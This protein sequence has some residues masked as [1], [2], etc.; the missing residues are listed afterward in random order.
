VGEETF[1]GE[2]CD[3]VDSI[4]RCERLWVSRQTG[5]LRGVVKYHRTGQFSQGLSGTLRMLPEIFKQTDEP[6]EARAQTLQIALQTLDDYSGPF[7]PNE[8][9]CFRDFRQ[10]APDAW[11]P[12]REDRAFTHSADSNVNRRK[13]IRLWW[14]AEEVRTDVDLAATIQILQPKEGDR[15]SQDQRFGLPLTYDYHPNRT[16]RELLELVQRERYNPQFEGFLSMLTFS[17]EKMAGEPARVLPAE[18]W[19]GGAVPRTHGTPHLLHFWA[20]W[21]SPSLDDFPSLKEL[22]GEGATILGIHPA[23][24]PAA[25]VAQVMA[26]HQLK[27]PTLLATENSREHFNQR[28]AGY[29][30][31]AYPHCVLIDAEGRIAAQGPLTP[32]LLE[33][34]R[35][36]R[37]AAKK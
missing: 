29:P 16:P 35:E 6:D 13:Y 22:A 11:F 4:R 12:F 14:S 1:D 20:E 23:G 28:I 2:L 36:L 18:G 7:E 26:E 19:I 30:V 10:I 37:Q 25:K 34:F 32:A 3:V 15:I 5:W 24:T 8:L 27:Y 31:W 9:V 17:L 21:A 33:R